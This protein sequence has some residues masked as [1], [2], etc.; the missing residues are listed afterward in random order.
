MKS[1]LEQYSGKVIFVLLSLTLLVGFFF[2][3]DSAGS[4][5]F[6]A[7]YNNTWGYVEELKKSFF[8]LPWGDKHWVGHTPL[9]FIIL[10]KVYLI[11]EDK[12]LLRLIFCVISILL[13]A[14]FYVC[15]KINYPAENKNNSPHVMSVYMMYKYML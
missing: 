14:L 6:I 3:E 1:Y 13:P 2:G 15:L 9:H 11:I 5:G 12:Y 10:S 7:D 8:V 4:G